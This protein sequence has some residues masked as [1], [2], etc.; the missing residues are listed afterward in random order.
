MQRGRWLVACS[1]EEGGAPWWW[2]PSER[3]SCRV[4][5]HLWMWFTCAALGG[6][7]LE[8]FQFQ[9]AYGGGCIVAMMWCASRCG[10]WH[11]VYIMKN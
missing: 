7:P 10:V 8:G 6:S 11:H 5:A 4:D 9:S 1:V 3:L 2:S